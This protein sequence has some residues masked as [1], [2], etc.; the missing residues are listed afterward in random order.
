MPWRRCGFSF[1]FLFAA[2]YST[3]TDGAPPVS[4]GVAASVRELLNAG[5]KGEFSK[6]ETYWRSNRL[7]ARRDARIDYAWGLVLRKHGKNREAGRQFLAA[8]GRRNPT[9]LAARQAVIW[10]KL[11][12]KESSS[13]LAQL[14]LLVRAVGSG[15][16]LEK[17]DRMAAARWIGMVLAA[18]EKQTLSRRDA[19]RAKSIRSRVT[20]QFQGELAKAIIAGEA[21]LTAKITELEAADLK[22]KLLAKKQK[23]QQVAKKE[24]SLS[25]KK[26]KA[27]E[28]T[29]AIKRSAEQWKEWLDA[30]EKSSKVLLGRQMKEFQILERRRQSLLRSMAL[31]AQEHNTRKTRFQQAIQ[32]AGRNRQRRD[33]LVNSANQILGRLEN[34]YA[35]YYQQSVLTFAQMFRIRQNALRVIQQYKRDAKQYESITG[36]LAQRGNALSKYQDTL[37]RAQRKLKNQQVR[38]SLSSKSKTRTKYRMTRLIEF[39][40]EAEGARLLKSLAKSTSP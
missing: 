2:V 3:A 8:A 1:A 19:A 15:S 9:Y 18:F 23:K 27:V 25:A 24:K 30:K 36:Q 11:A 5:L 4:S 33:L 26:E 31:L 17:T 7:A 32:A 16:G 6:A 28:K 10:L 34:E 37:D 13:A 39:D 21:D 35:G 38:S 22:R 20:R 14:D 12:S 29:K 40:L